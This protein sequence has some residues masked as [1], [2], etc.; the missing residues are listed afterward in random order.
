MTSVIGGVVIGVIGVGLVVLCA[1]D[2]HRVTCQA[3]QDLESPLLSNGV[4]P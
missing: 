4:L 1:V 3:R 2:M